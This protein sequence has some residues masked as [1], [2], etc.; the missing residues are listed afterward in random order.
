MIITI[1]SEKGGVGKSTLTLNLG[2][3]L[4]ARG[5][6]VCLIDLDAQAA[7]LTDLCGIES[8]G[9]DFYSALRRDTAPPLIKTPLPNYTLDLIAG[10]HELHD[11]SRLFNERPVPTLAL[12]AYLEAH[13]LPHDVV[14]IDTPPSLGPVQFAAMAA[15]DHVLIPSP[16]EHSSA[17]G[18]LSI[19]QNIQTFQSSG[20]PVKLLG[21]VPYRHPT[22][23][24]DG[25]QQREQWRD[26]VGDAHVAPTI[27]A[28]V[29][30]PRSAEEGQALRDYAPDCPAV[31]HFEALTQW[32][33][34]LA[35]IH[36]NTER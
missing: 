12:R 35:N 23:S 8:D 11:L 24:A 14:L 9:W 13:P 34:D 21:V 22:R 36:E 7:G 18:A 20:L 25:K 26:T 29:D 19:L 16:P 28:Y 27:G 6:R 32:A 10:G 4:A 31:Q 3:H 33:I 30:V 1:A 2:V 17:L 5:L 15:A